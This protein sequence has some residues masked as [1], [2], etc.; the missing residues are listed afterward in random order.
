M[1]IKEEMKMDNT[2]LDYIAW[3]Q[4]HEHGGNTKENASN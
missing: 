4:D 2:W 3:Q 1:V